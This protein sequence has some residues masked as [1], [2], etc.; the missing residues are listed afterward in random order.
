M[1]ANFEHLYLSIYYQTIMRSVEKDYKYIRE[2]DEI[3]KFWNKVYF[4]IEN[5][6]K[7]EGSNIITVRILKLIDKH[8]NSSLPGFQVLSMS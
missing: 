8:F 1:S 5:V 7:I 2:G 3:N 6:V 4:K